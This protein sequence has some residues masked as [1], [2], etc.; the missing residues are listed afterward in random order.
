MVFETANL[1]GLR[2]FPFLC[3]NSSPRVGAVALE[4]ARATLPASLVEQ[5]L[6]LKKMKVSAARAA[7]KLAKQYDVSR[8]EQDAFSCESH[9]RAVAAQKE[10]PLRRRDHADD[11]RARRALG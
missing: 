10:G 4:Q 9:R 3:S 1:S 8:E 2:I 11:H 5:K 7:E 6:A